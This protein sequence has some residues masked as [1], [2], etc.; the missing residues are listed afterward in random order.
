MSEKDKPK[1]CDTC[2]DRIPCPFYT[3]GEKCTKTE[4]KDDN[5][6]CAGCE[7]EKLKSN[8]LPCWECECFD[9]YEPRE[10]DYQ[11]LMEVHM[12]LI[13]KYK[14]KCC[15]VSELETL[16]EVAEQEIKELMGDKID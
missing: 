4:K 5:D 1:W 16:L 10:D 3:A 13:K 8:Q 15:R 9:K 7:H 2:E 6:S 14:N 11:T 12:E